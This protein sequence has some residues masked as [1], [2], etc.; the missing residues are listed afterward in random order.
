MRASVV[1]LFCGVGG[2]THGFVQ[3]GFDVVAG[4]DID[5]SC[6]YAYE[7]NNPSKFILKDISKLN[8]DE[9]TALF[10][11]NAV[12]VLVGCAPCQPFSMYNRLK[13]NTDKWKLLYQFSRLIDEVKPEIVSMENV[14]QLATYRSSRVFWNFLKVLK[15]NDY[16]VSYS[17]VKC[18][19]YGVPQR[20]KRLV[21]LASR[22]G[23]DID[24]IPETHKPE[25]Y[26]TVEDTISELNPVKAGESDNV[27]PLHRARGLSDLNL[28]RLKATPAGGDW[29]DWPDELILR[30]H[31]KKRGRTFKSVYGRMRWDDLAPT[32]TTQCIGIGNG[33]FGHPEQDR[34][35]T[36][37]EAA[38]FQSFPEEYD[39]IDPEADFSSHKLA[40]HIGN[41][42]PVRLGRVIA[43]SIKRHLKLTHQ[44]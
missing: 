21:L 4:I 39:F 36:L 16:K 38:L 22:L 44:E 6:R 42:V 13:N 30:C 3:E 23:S 29:R 5:P 41:A 37:R 2:I 40:I 17:V 33:R 31:R 25:D 15:N 43:Q 19:N 14:P 9:V 11:A 35:I 20:R 8:G 28:I 12:R 34:A 24:L 10:P 18:Q 32:I 7:K 1:D 27:D 26:L